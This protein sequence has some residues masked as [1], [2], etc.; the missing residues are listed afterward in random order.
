MCYHMKY[1]YCFYFYKHKLPAQEITHLL[2]QSVQ[3]LFF[4]FITHCV[5]KSYT[6]CVR[7]LS[8]KP[9]VLFFDAT[10]FAVLF[11]FQ[12]WL[13]SPLPEDV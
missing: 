4:N 2:C 5:L 11:L 6:T 12:K 7:M 8:T 13:S 9:S 3:R 1:M 10:V